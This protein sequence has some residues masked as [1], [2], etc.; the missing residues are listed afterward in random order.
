MSK[1]CPLIE[2]FVMRR[3]FYKGQTLEELPFS[4]KPL[5]LIDQIFSLLVHPFDGKFAWW[6]T[7][8]RWVM[9]S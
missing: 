3:S 9:G 8:T 7:G 6:K 5:A 4:D 2:S 1:S